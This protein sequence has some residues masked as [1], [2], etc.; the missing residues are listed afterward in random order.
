MIPFHQPATVFIGPACRNRTHI[1]GLEDPCIIHYTNTGNLVREAGFEPA[2]FLMWEILSLLRFTNFATLAIIALYKVKCNLASGAS[3]GIR[4]RKILI[5][6]QTRIPVP[7]PRLM[8]E[9]PQ[10]VLFVL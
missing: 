3:G 6:S 8:H 1:Q 4:T 9:Y 5:L 7:S 2:M 10:F